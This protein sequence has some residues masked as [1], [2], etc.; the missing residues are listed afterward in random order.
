MLAGIV[1]PK[2]HRPAPDGLVE[3]IYA[4]FNE[5]VFDIPETQGK[6]EIQPHRMLDYKTG[7]R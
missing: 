7:K 2:L 4:T 6:P 5:E 1:Q 3:D